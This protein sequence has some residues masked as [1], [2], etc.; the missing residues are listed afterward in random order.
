MGA[1]YMDYILADPIVIPEEH[2]AFYTENIVDLPDCYQANDDKRVVPE[3]A[4]TRAQAGLPEP[5]FVF[6]CFNNSFKIT[7]RIFDVWMRLLKS[8]DRSVLWLLD[9]NP[10]ATANL[11]REA[12]ARGVPASRL[13]F[14][15]RMKFEDHLARHSLAD[16]FLDTLPC[17]A[18]TTASDA[19]WM[20]LPV[21]TVPGA[22]FAGRVAASIVSAAGVPELIAPS[23]DGYE[24][25]ARE[26]ARNPERVVRMKARLVGHR[27]S[28]PLF[29]T[30]RFT[31]HLEAAFTTMWQ[32]YQGGAPP[33]AFAVAR[34]D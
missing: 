24:A 33:A 26:L 3:N 23:L 15:P 30:A 17:N 14:A 10:D 20:G 7:P 22:T 5:G 31:R 2:R 9:D 11:K 12:E 21:L 18:H 27:F 28:A 29:D 16:L 19:L 34:S 6:A 32:R 25:M 8:V 4:P 13:V 1:P